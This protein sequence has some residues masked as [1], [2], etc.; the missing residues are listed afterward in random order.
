M[1]IP[2]VLKGE[3]IN[4]L[5]NVEREFPTHM[6]HCAMKYK[7]LKETYFLFKYNDETKRQSTITYLRKSL[8]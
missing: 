8:S 3:P 7:S 5:V 2:L 4:T 6:Y 1:V